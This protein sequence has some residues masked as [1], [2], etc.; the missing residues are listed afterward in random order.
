MFYFA[1]DKLYEKK[2]YEGR[3]FEKNMFQRNS[4]QVSFYL[5]RQL[6][7]KT[8][9]AFRTRVVFFTLP[10]YTIVSLYVNNIKIS[11]YIHVLLNI[12]VVKRLFEFIYIKFKIN[13]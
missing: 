12:Y 5:P 6:F 2:K 11:I 10:K 4:N 8:F 1:Y 9:Y 7:D 13:I 3:D